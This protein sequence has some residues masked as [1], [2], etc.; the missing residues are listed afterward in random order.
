[1]NNTIKLIIS[2]N[3]NPFNFFLRFYNFHEAKNIPLKKYQLSDLFVN[4]KNYL[5]EDN[6]YNQ[7]IDDCLKLDYLLYNNIKPKIYWDNQVNKQDVLR[8]FF[9]YNQKYPIDLLY[10]YALVS[11]YKLGYIIVIY[12]EKEKIIYYYSDNQTKR[13][14]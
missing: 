11:H 12:L 8:E 3:L 7:E 9:L 13:I 5:I 4:L 2:K 14:S 10:K 6:T 1:M